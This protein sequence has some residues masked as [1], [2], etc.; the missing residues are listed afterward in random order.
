MLET[1]NEVGQSPLHYAIELGHVEIA[2]ILLDQSADVNTKDNDDWT[3][4]ISAAKLGN[5]EEL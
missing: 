3:P 1:R 4:L 2:Q 5:L